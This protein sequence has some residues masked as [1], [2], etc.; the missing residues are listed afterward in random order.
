MLAH[1]KI[2]N[3]QK[4]NKTHIHKETK[5]T[6]FAWLY[7]IYKNIRPRMSNSKADRLMNYF[8]PVQRFLW[9]D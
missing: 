3:T 5:I 8:L 6:R 7:N 2:K 4:K 1:T 9:L